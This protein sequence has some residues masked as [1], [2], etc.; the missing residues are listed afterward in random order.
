MK[1]GDPSCRV[2][3]LDLRRLAAGRWSDQAIGLR[4]GTTALLI[5]CNDVVEVIPFKPVSPLPGERSIGVFFQRGRPVTAIDPISWSQSVDDHQPRFWVIVTLSG[6]VVG[7]G[8][9]SVVADV[10][11]TAAVD[12]SSAREIGSFRAVP[13]SWKGRLAWCL[14]SWWEQPVRS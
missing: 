1:R 9:D 8:A 4:R 3:A 7:L 14:G 5:R 10:W 11:L 13:V 2:N 6:D 12:W